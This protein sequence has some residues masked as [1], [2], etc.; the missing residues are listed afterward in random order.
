[1]EDTPDEV[2]RPIKLAFKAASAI[3]N[4]WFAAIA[5]IVLGR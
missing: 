3:Q 1:M 4:C 2:G 5:K